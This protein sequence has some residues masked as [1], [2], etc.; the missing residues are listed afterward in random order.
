MSQQ[1]PS[2]DT[3]N[4]PLDEECDLFLRRYYDT[5]I[6]ELAENY[7]SEKSLYVDWMDLYRLDED[8]ADDYL[9]NPTQ[10]G[11]EL[12][13][14]LHRYDLPVDVGFSQA[15]V[16]VRNL[17]SEE[18]I[19]SKPSTLRNDQ[20]GHY[21]GIK[22]ELKR[23]T[24]PDEKPEEIAWECQRCG[25]LT[26]LSV[27]GNDLPEPHECQG[28]ERQGPWEINHDQTTWTDYCKVRIETPPDES[29]DGGGDE[30]DGYIEGDL[31]DY[32][33]PA[34]LYARAGEKAIVYGV[35]ERQQKNPDG[36]KGNNLLY[37]RVLRV[38]AVEFDADEDSINIEDHRDEFEKLA[39]EPDA[40][41]LFAESLVPQLYAT[42]E[43]EHALELGVAY[44]FAAPR[45]DIPQGPSYRGDIHG[46]IMSGYGM[47]KSMFNRALEAYSP[48]AILKSATALSSDVGLLAA[49]VKDDFGEGQWTIKPGIL[50]RGNGGHVILDEIDKTGAELSRMNDALE[51]SQTVDVEKAGQNATYQSRVGLFATGNPE[52]GRFNKH[53]PVSE[54]LGVKPSLLSRFDGIIH[55]EDKEN[56][57]RDAKIAGTVG[58]AYVESQ[59][60]QFGDREELDELDAPVSVDVGRAWVAEARENYQPLLSVEQVDMIKDWYASEVR[61]LNQK[62]ADNEGQGADMPVPATAR[63]VEGTI[64]FS[65][66]F[67]RCHLRD[68]VQDTDVERA[69]SLMKALIGQTFDGEMFGPEEVKGSQHDRVKSLLELLRRM[70]RDREGDVPRE[71]AFEQA[72]EELGLRESKIEH[73]I[74]KLKQ[75]GELMSPGKDTLRTT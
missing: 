28:C 19:Y 48:D 40:V 70:D 11:D 22:G 60:M 8:L 57:E 47:G 23:I 21:V 51:G 62:F 72:S 38:R 73:E 42:P 54:Q 74:D 24:T 75:K 30:I 71:E 43:W 50:V 15:T 59:E 20:G 39:Q 32:G 2:P 64:R 27:A 44:L 17:N 9:T 14:A 10:I 36:R 45:I 66:A 33:H 25:T 31:V 56:E 52:D 4:M 35:L 37:E 16:R 1:Y 61:Q 63:V 69:K 34:G 53:E 67:A 7:P 58:R 29:D 5:E 65:V 46:L 41:D 26:Y 6:K 55:M 13:K 49:A 3:D 18:D 12:D 68:E